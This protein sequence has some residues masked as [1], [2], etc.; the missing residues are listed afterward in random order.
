MSPENVVVKRGAVAG[1]CVEAAEQ[2]TTGHV[3]EQVPTLLAPPEYLAAHHVVEI[4]RVGVEL[5]LSNSVTKPNTS[6]M[7]EEEDWPAHIRRYQGCRPCAEW[8]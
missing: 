6:E 5:A 4:V 2:A 3:H 8:S 7:R 1:G